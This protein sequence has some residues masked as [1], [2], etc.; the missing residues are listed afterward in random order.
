MSD[1]APDPY[2]V[3]HEESHPPPKNLWDRLKYLG[4]S[5][6]VTGGVIGSG[7]LVLTTSLGAAVGFG[8]LWWMMRATKLT[9]LVRG[10]SLSNAGGQGKCARYMA[11]TIASLKLTSKCSRENISPATARGATKMVI[12]G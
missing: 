8:L 4:P 7:E 6:V 1:A 5:L 9:V 3:R 2:T 10:R 11:I 12:T